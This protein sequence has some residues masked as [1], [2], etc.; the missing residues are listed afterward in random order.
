[1]RKPTKLA[2]V[3]EIPSFAVIIRCCWER[4]ATQQEAL[5]ELKRRGLWL[6]ED[7]KRQAGLIE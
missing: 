7:Q 6:S 4:G 1:M 5:A 2:P 3:T